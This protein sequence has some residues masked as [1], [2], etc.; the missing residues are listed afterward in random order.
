MDGVVLETALV[1]MGIIAVG[2]GVVDGR[3]VCQ[4]E[5]SD[6]RPINVRWQL[7]FYLITS[8]GNAIC[9]RTD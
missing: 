1:V 4:A 7:S 2:R 6:G 3:E 5:P 9:H 8:T